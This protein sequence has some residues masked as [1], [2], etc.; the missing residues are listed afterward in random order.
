MTKTKSKFARFMKSF[1]VSCHK[2]NEFNGVC[3]DCW[4]EIHKIIMRVGRTSFAG[5]QIANTINFAS[6]LKDDEWHPLDGIGEWKDKTNS[7]NL[8][9]SKKVFEERKERSEKY[10]I[11]T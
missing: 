7:H 4:A 1:N 8:G 3:S 10:F 2:H 5:K 11:H 9:W 6:K